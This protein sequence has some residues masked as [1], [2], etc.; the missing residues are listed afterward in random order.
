V[1]I[2]LPLAAALA[3]LAAPA[4]VA[5]PTPS[6]VVSFAGSG[7]E[8]HV[9]QQQN[10]QDDG[11]CDS[12]EHVDVTATLSWQ[13]TWHGLRGTGRSVLGA[14]VLS[15]AGSQVAG[16]H[17]KDACGLPLDEAPPGWVS[18][19]SCNT[20]LV[21]SAAPE[22][23]VASRSKTALTLSLTAPALAV[24]AGS[25]CTL[26]VR[27]DQLATHVVVPL[28]KL[29]ALRK[30]K[31]LTLA[32]GTS[33]PGPGDEYAPSLDCSQPT[34]PYEGYRTADHCQDELTWS[35]TVRVTRAS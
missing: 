2:A 4:A 17:V 12:A 30:G 18:Q 25:G 29:A 35:G 1:R 3:L 34:K 8:H 28:K 24:P 32:V 26:N 11:T 33:L 14:P 6:Y 31:S 27:N 16:T 23:A 19:Q 7:T 22:L 15:T 5:M 20:A 9:D 10:I 13:A 21:D